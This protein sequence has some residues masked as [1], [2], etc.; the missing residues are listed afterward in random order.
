MNILLLTPDAVGG[1]LLERTLTVYT[2]FH[3]FDRPIIEVGHLE[4]GLHKY[5]C[6][7]HN[8]EI[9]TST[10]PKIE[11]QSLTDIK[12]ML[13]S[14]KH[15]KIAK[16][17]HYNMLSRKDP[18]DQQMPFYQYL[19]QNYFIIACRRNNLFEHAISWSLN[20]IT[21][22]LNVHDPMEKI[23]TF[24]NMYKDGVSI[25]P[26]SLV[27]SLNDYK[28][29]LTWCEDHFKIA[30]YYTYETH[31]TDIENYILSLPIFNGQKKL[32]KWQDVY[33]QEFN[34]WNKCH[35]FSSDLS[36]LS[37]PNAASLE[38]LT[39]NVT[40]SNQKIFENMQTHWTN[41]VGEYNNI[42][43][44]LWPK[45]QTLT[46]FENLPEWIKNECRDRH[47]ITWN[48]DKIYYYRNLVENKYSSPIV[49]RTSDRDSVALVA[50]YL[51]DQHKEFLNQHGTQ[52]RIANTSMEKMKEIGILKNTIPIKKQTL[53]EKK[54]IV[55]NFEEC[56]EVYNKWIAMHPDL[57]SPMTNKSLT[58][59]IQNEEGFWNGTT[60]NPLSLIN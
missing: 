47:D 11:F 52:Y 24:F 45:L 46:D 25:D 44:P 8:Q 37:L 55:T 33:G 15:Y 36:T 9:V 60:A 4:L 18:M 26:I 10:A 14:T 20:K 56:I 32:F 38:L 42:A 34:D 6:T 21:K 30:S 40:I 12:D 28:K 7:H 39:D 59:R 53:A 16:L 50:D 57:G 5:Y 41:F 3:Q 48:L 2:Q 22:S 43:D 19:N 54:F 27:H 1:T 13:E 49:K 58:I 17:P 51:K 31:S 29:Y 23:G 35:Y